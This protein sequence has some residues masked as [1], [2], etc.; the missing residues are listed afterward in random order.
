M[1]IVSASEDIFTEITCIVGVGNGFRQ[2]ASCIEQLAPYIYI[3]G[4]G[5]QGETGN[6]HSLD[7]RMRR[8]AHQLAIFK[9]TGFAFVRITYQITRYA[10]WLGQE[11]PFQFRGEDGTALSPDR[12]ST[13]LN[14]RH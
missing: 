9:S 6:D 4:I 3:G 7:E 11:T 12:K 14:S 1:Q 10:L 13:R 8:L 5:P 2:H